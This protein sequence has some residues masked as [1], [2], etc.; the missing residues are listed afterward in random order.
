[1]IMDNTNAFLIAQLLSS[2]E[3]RDFVLQSTLNIEFVCRRMVAMANEKG[4]TILVGVDEHRQVVGVDNA[5]RVMDNLRQYTHE[6]VFPPLTCSSRVVDYEG[7][8]VLLI[9]IWEGSSKPYLLDKASYIFVGD[10]VVR[11]DSRLMGLLFDKRALHDC[12]WERER[13][14]EASLHDIDMDRVTEV[15]N[16]AIVVN[17]TLRGLSA[18]EF[19]VRQGLLIQGLPTNACVVLFARFPAQ[20]LPQT[21]IRLSVYAGNN[22]RRELLEVRLFEG[23][24]FDNLD[25]VTNHIDSLYGKRMVVES[26]ERREV[27]ILP[28]VAFREG[29]LNAIVHRDYSVHRSFLNIVVNA[30][31]LQIINYGG[32]MD[33]ITVD[34]LRR[35]HLSVLR[36]PD[37]ANVCYLG[38]YIEVAG[39]GTLRILDECKKTAGMTAE[40]TEESGV[41]AL[42]LSGIV[43]SRGTRVSDNP[44]RVQNAAVQAML[45]KIVAFVGQNEYC[46]LSDIQICVGKSL[47][48]TK[49]YVQLLKENDV[50][51]YIGALKDGGYR[52]KL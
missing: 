22:D 49:R 43:C 46:K 28:L 25:S 14:Y 36:N 42:T 9:S 24:L 30:D 13:V 37:I 10:E 29:L 21:R 12:A 45:D 38:H 34:S 47:A 18:E 6:H 20:F 2:H 5:T 1:M 31:N 4:G 35:E 16:K 40:W 15:L 26:L 27:S 50:I 3:A 23:N 11:A 32:L 51:E 39:S 48:T 44:V 33:G 52:L 8:H 17:E 19:L 7:R 41:V